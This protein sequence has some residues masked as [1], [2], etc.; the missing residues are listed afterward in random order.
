METPQ[1]KIEKL[2]TKLNFSIIIIDKPAGPTSFTISDFVRKKFKEFNISKTSHFGTLDPMVTGVL[3]IAIGRACKL[4]GMFLGHDKKYI[5][6]MHLHKEIS[7]EE[8]QKVIDKEFTGMI[9][10]MP[11]KKS[12]VKRQLR[13]REIISFKITKKEDKDF[14]FETEVQGG[15]YIRKLVHDLGE[16]TGLGAHMTELRRTKAGIFDNSK[17]YTL[18]QLEE[19]I[20]QFKE[21]KIELLDNMLIPAEKAIKEVFPFIT[22]DNSKKDLVR[23]LLTGRPIFKSDFKLPEGEVFAIFLEDKFVE[24]AKKVKERDNVVARPEFVYN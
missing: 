24:I 18:T 6:T 10:Q 20:K 11:P 19:A 9:M 4:T 17:I 7:I 13:E 3:P 14:F 15:T 8:L 12:A 5:G 23:K 1:Q 21:G 16:K 22:L 2:K